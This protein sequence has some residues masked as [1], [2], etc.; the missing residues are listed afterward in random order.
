MNIKTYLFFILIFSFKPIHAQYLELK[1]CINEQINN[2]SYIINYEIEN[3]IDVFDSIQKLENYLINE[4]I[5]KDR[6]LESYQKLNQ[7]KTENL[8]INKIFK[9]FPFLFALNYESDYLFGNYNA[10]FYNVSKTKMKWAKQLWPEKKVYDK[11]I[12]EGP[13]NYNIVNQLSETINFDNNVS[14]FMLCNLVYN[15]WVQDYKDEIWRNKKR[16]K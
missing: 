3:E 6:N 8:D 10:C 15:K 9:D 4:K 5:L 1:N 12:A 7:R 16:E 13:V 11:I 2:I 14:R